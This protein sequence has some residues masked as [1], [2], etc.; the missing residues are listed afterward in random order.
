MIQQNE[1]VL[2]DQQQMN[3]SITRRSLALSLYSLM[4]GTVL[5]SLL[6][7]FGESIA[8]CHIQTVQQRAIT[9]LSANSAQLIV[10]RVS[11]K[12][13]DKLQ[14]R[15]GKECILSGIFYDVVA[16]KNENEALVLT[17]LPDPEETALQKKLGLKLA[18]SRQS[19]REQKTAF[20]G[21][22][23][24][25]TWH[26]TQLPFFASAGIVP[27]PYCRFVDEPFLGISLPPPRV[28]TFC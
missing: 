18:H 5:L 19:R 7:G 4:V 6:C 10:L 21:F 17:L 14:V 3:L 24:Y 8:I 27:I 20:A 28:S 11:K 25:E 15:A 16:L 23:F 26:A 9:Q 22:L 13:F 12:E 2:P 1:V